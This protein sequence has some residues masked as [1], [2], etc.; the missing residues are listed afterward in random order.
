MRVLNC[1]LDN[2]FGGPHRRAKIISNELKNEDIKTLFLVNEKIKGGIPFK[3]DQ[4]FLIRHIQII[5]RENLFTNFI[6]FILFFPLNV[7]KICKLIS[8]EKISILHVNGLLNVIPLI[9]GKLMKRKVLLHLNDTSFPP[10]LKPF[11]LRM[12][13][14]L[15]DAIAVTSKAV[16]KYYFEKEDTPKHVPL[17]FFPV[18]VDTSM[19]S[20]KI[21]ETKSNEVKQKFGLSTDAYIVGTVGNVNRIKGYEYFLAA[22]AKAKEKIPN[23]IYLIVG[24]KIN[25]QLDYYDN[26]VELSQTEKLKGTVVFTGFQENVPMMLSVMDIF[27]LPSL[28]ESGPLSVLEALSMKIPVVATDVGLVSEVVKTGETG[29]LVKPKDVDGIAE[30]ICHIHN[31]SGEKLRRYKERG[32]DQVK[33]LFSPEKVSLSYIAAYRTMMGS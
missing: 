25:T 24:E 5:N 18:P 31:L 22:A 26:L 23:I 7:W 29:F 1:M 12:M 16:Y 21:Y 10:I 6:L 20:N 33:K 2:R 17:F 8:S 27:V 14:H 30:G 13:L 9:A 19:F 3:K 11:L 32:R 15:T 4:C 28:S